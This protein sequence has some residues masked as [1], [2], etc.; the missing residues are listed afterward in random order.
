MY[1]IQI[2]R[3]FSCCQ[4]KTIYIFMIFYIR[5]SDISPGPWKPPALFYDLVSFWHFD[6]WSI[7]CLIQ[8][9]FN[10]MSQ[11]LLRV[12][13]LRSQAPCVRSSPSM[14]PAQQWRPALSS[15]LDSTGTSKTPG[16]EH[17]EEKTG[18]SGLKSWRPSTSQTKTMDLTSPVLPVILWKV[19]SRR[20]RKQRLS[21]FPVSVSWS[22]FRQ[23][24]LFSLRALWRLV[25]VSLDGPKNT[26][27][28]VSPE[29]LLPTGSLV[30]LNCSSR[31]KPPIIKFT[32][33]RISQDGREAKVNVWEGPVYSFN[34]TQAGVYLC[35]ASHSLSTDSSTIELTIQGNCTDCPP[36]DRLV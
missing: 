5:C 29:G 17:G 7:K 33:F 2:N 23:Q 18:S 6:L 13:K 8:N 25:L 15:L 14:W 11:I 1:K 16:T 36:L 10:L 22:A 9:L 27:V 24:R 26:K 19:P 34:L 30:T 28:S 12:L 4:K 35:E 3:L 20:Q 21:T 32:W 31:A